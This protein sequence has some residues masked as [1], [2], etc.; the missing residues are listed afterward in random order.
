MFCR[1][2]VVF[3]AGQKVTERRHVGRPPFFRLCGARLNLKD[4]TCMDAS[5]CKAPFPPAELQKCLNAATFAL[6]ENVRLANDIASANLDG[7]ENCPD[8]CFAMV[9]EASFQEHPSLHCLNPDCRLVSCR[10]CHKKVRVYWEDCLALAAPHKDTIHRS[11]QGNRAMTRRRP[12][13]KLNT[14]LKKL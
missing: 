8:C 6:L 13:A 7:L 4:V 14:Q 2:C 10:K 12:N 11:I 3:L 1:E 5:G 9:I